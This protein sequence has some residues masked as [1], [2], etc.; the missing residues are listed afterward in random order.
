[1]NGHLGVKPLFL[2]TYIVSLRFVVPQPFILSAE[3]QFLF[4]S[5][6]CILIYFV[7]RLTRAS[8]R[9]INI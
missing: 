3:V 1:M 2:F 6:D 9:Y 5:S 8:S 4:V 7:P